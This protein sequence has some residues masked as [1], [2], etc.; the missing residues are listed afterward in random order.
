[1]N[2]MWTAHYALTLVH[3]IIVFVLIRVISMTAFDGDTEVC[4]V[5]ILFNVDLSCLAPGLDP[6]RT[7]T[8][9]SNPSIHILLS[10]VCPM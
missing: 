5:L 3:L 2:D 9:S 4:F 6:S 10:E 7:N 1:M 8:I